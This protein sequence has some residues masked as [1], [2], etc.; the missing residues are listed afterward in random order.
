MPIFCKGF[1][2][3]LF[4][5]IA[6]AGLIGNCFLFKLNGKMLPDGTKGIRG[7]KMRFPAWG[8]H[9]M[10]ASIIY[11]LT[12]LFNNIPSAIA[13]SIW[14]IQVSEKHNDCLFSVEVCVETCQRDTMG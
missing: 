12:Q 14:G 2:W 3:A 1:T 7:K 10:V 5:M 8:P 11:V 13:V 6:N 9:A 4:A